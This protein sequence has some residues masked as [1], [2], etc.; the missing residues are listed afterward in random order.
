MQV[1]WQICTFIMGNSVT[2]RHRIL[3]VNTVQKKGH[4]KQSFGRGAFL[5]LLQE[6]AWLSPLANARINVVELEGSWQA[7]FCIVSMV[8]NN[9]IRAL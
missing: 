1:R 4:E 2:R 3:V 6:T 9:I 5:L 7:Y 8:S